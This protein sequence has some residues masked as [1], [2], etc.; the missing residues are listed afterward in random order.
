MK[1]Q[2]FLAVVK[3][4]SITEMKFYGYVSSGLTAIASQLGGW[5]MPLKLLV[6][7]MIIDYITGVLK[8]FKT[9]TLNSDIMFW[10]G[11]RKGATVA[12]IYMAALLDSMLS[13][14]LPI[15]R[16]LA[17]YYYVAREGVSITENLATLG[18]PIP[19]VI[20]QALEQIKEKG[21]TVEGNKNKG[22]EK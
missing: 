1:S 18:V 5:D 21:D 14:N 20:L 17:I 10:G 16:T 9:K 6:A 7:F 12:V 2:G 13:D 15:F 19:P 3:S 4:E 11:I 8:G 22:D